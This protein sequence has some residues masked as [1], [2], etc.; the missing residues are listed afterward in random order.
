M[1]SCRSSLISDYGYDNKT[2]E[3]DIRFVSGPTWRYSGVPLDTF[4]EFLR[5]GSKGK[6]FNANIKGKFP[7]EK[8]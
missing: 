8:V 5:S 7:E 6:H 4:L 3:L 2:Q 1:H